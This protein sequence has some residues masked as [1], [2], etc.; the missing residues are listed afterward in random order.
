[1]RI[2]VFL[3]IFNMTSSRKWQPLWTFL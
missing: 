1:L 3:L 2:Q